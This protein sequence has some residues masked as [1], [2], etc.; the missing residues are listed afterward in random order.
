[1]HNYCCLYQ[2][3]T[4]T[5]IF[6]TLNFSTRGR[7][8]RLFPARYFHPCPLQSSPLS[9]EFSLQPVHFSRVFHAF[10]SPPPS[11]LPVSAQTR[12]NSRSLDY[13]LC[14]G[15]YSTECVS[16]SNPFS[17]YTIP[18]L[19][20][21]YSKSEWVCKVGGYHHAA[22]GSTSLIQFTCLYSFRELYLQP[23]FSNWISPLK[24]R[25]IIKGCV[26]V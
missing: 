1:M 19:S 14:P 4:T 20:V 18:L 5:I 7:L 17:F 3:T 25:I 23:Y 21:C 12:D 16:C 24:S 10:L 13:L 9:R 15:S 22:Q 11:R 2:T 8:E 26:G 6:R